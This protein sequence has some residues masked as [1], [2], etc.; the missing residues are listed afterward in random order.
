V[1]EHIA[2]GVDAE[3]LE[4]T[5][6]EPA[7]LDAVLTPCERQ[8]LAALSPEERQVAFLALWTLK[9]ALGKAMGVGLR[10]PLT[11]IGFALDP[12]RLTELPAALG[13][14]SSWQFYQ[15]RL[16]THLL[17]LAISRAGSSHPTLSLRIDEIPTP[18]AE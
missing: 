7:L 16:D 1:S 12:I 15:R 2:V 17:A 14:C 3:R 8:R 10:L 4:E 9:E 5:P 13:S 11:T 18:H 6:L